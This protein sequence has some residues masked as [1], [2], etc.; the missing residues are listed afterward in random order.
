MD[1]MF[2][3]LQKSSCAVELTTN[4]RSEGSIIFDNASKI[5]RREEPLFDKYAKVTVQ[6]IVQ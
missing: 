3:S 1:D 5:S 6:N 2:M 4:H